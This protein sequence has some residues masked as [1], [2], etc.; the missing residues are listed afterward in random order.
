MLMKFYISDIIV[1]RMA[2][3]DMGVLEWTEYLFQI[4]KENNELQI[5]SVVDNMYDANKENMDSR[6]I[7]EATKTMNSVN[8]EGKI[9]IRFS[10]VSL[11]QGVV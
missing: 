9:K 7:N 10:C 3:S 8:N 11:F 1:F 5:S 2:D 6:K 4:E